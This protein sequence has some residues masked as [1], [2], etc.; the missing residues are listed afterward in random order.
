MVSHNR[1]KQRRIGIFQPSQKIVIFCEG[2][3]TEV[4][5]FS[6]FKEIISSNPIYKHSIEVEVVGL[7]VGTLQVIQA[8]EDYV[9]QNSLEGANIWCVYDKDDFP[10][11]DFNSAEEKTKKLN[12][13]SLNRFSSAWSNQCIEY[14]FILHF[15]YYTSD[16]HRSEYISY[17]DSKFRKLDIGKYSK[18][19]E[20]IFEKL[21]E[22]GNPKQAIKFACKRMRECTLLSPSKSAPATKVHLLVLE[23]SKYLPEEM[24]VYFI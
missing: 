5:Y 2:T 12:E 15:D 21:L 13:T 23:L 18:S 8:A 22:Y 16:N 19:D 9:K 4:N 11:K 7:G 1:K 17:L 3:E 6:R 10:E 20:H 24:R 14:W